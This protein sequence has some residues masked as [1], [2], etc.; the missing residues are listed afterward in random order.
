MEFRRVANYRG[1]GEG[2]MAILTDGE[3]VPIVAVGVPSD[4]K[5]FFGVVGVYTCDG[6]FIPGSCVRGYEKSSE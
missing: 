1:V 6:L 5:N 4:T 2:C 3:R